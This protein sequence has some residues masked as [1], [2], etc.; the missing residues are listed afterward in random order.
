MRQLPVRPAYARAVL[1][2]EGGGVW[3]GPKNVSSFFSGGNLIKFERTN[4]EKIVPGK[5]QKRED[6]I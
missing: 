2:T 4:D 6:E 1:L 5:L 3:Y